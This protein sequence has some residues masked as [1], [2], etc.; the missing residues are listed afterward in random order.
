M[1]ESGQK[2][3]VR[4]WREPAKVKKAIAD[5][6]MAIPKENWAVSQV[7]DIA[8]ATK[9]VIRDRAG[10]GYQDVTPQPIDVSNLRAGWPIDGVRVMVEAAPGKVWLVKDLVA[11]A[12][13]W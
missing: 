6:R 11:A 5:F 7:H 13:V 2:V 12:D 3:R 1:S 9:H 8:N 4:F 10:V